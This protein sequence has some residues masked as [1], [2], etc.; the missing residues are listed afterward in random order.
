MSEELKK[1]LLSFIWRLGAIMVVAGLSF[2]LENISE[3]GL[4]V[5]IVGV[6]GLAVGE[7]TKWINN[8]YQIGKAIVAGINK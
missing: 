7:L 4:P 2:I 6:V 5:W 8:K 3:I 1:R